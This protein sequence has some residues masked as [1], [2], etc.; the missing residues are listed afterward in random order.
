MKKAAW[1][2]VI[3]VSLVACGD[4]DGGGA[5][6]AGRMDGGRADSGR[7]PDAGDDDD[8]RVDPPDAGM[9]D[10]GDAGED[11][12]DASGDA[13]EPDA[14]VDPCEG[15]PEA[16]RC[17]L[18]GMG[19]MGA[20]LFVCAPNAAGCF[21]Q[22]TTDCSATGQTCG[23][24]P[25]GG[26]ACI[27]PPCG[28]GVIDEREA[29]D[30]DG[31]TPGDGCS[32]TCTVEPGFSC[33]GTPSVC[34]PS[35][36]NGSCA[37]AIAL[38]GTTAADVTD[39]GARPT[40]A[41][42][43][44]GTGSALYYALTVPA[45]TQIHVTA[46]PTTPWD[47]TLHGLLDCASAGCST[48]SDTAGRMPGTE[49]VTF[50]NDSEAPITRIVA[51]A[52]ATTEGGSF[53]LSTS[54]NAI[55]FT[56]IPAACEPASS[57]PTTHF[58]GGD[59]AVTPFAPLPFGV[60]LFGVSQTHFAVS[61]NGLLQ[62]STSASDTPSDTGAN[63]TIPTGPLPN[64]LVAAFWDDLVVNTSGAVRSWIVGSSPMRKLVVEWND[65][66]FFGLAGASL[67]IQAQLYETTGVI[68]LHY[69]TLSGTFLVVRG[70]GATIGLEDATGVTGRLVS[71][72]TRD[73]IAAGDGI[74][75]T[76]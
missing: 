11:P 6:D 64:S 59:D 54:A 45:R 71:F 31:T 44:G 56:A 70:S 13:A 41:L 34:A 15:V 46:T 60:P 7:D 14:E 53:T 12:I 30:D 5:V 25:S 18:D 49:R 36:G 57:A 62:L 67:R 74:R 35:T 20:M 9:R 37:G 24:V 42:C 27:E 73:A 50:T 26:L 51:V 28:N 65:M 2:W 29:C 68:E 17:D 32:E 58:S 72:N 48:F 16:E 69:C 1:A 8:A 22:T 23:R 75:F 19:C 43:G 47:V 55:P 33:S 38:T 39:G 61:T 76:P 4:D 40:G 63:F 52:A 66:G 10:A 21:V 3:V